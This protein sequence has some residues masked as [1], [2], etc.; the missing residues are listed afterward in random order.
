MGAILAGAVPT[1]PLG[2]WLLADLSDA[3]MRIVVSLLVLAASV[4]VW[5]GFLFR[6][7][8]GPVSHGLA[9]AVSG[10][11]FGMAAIGGLPVVIYLLAAS[12]AAATT[13]AVLALHLML[14]GLYGAAV[15]GAFGLFT[16]ESL[17]RVML[18][19]PP[20]LAGVAIG[21]RH[22]QASSHR[23]WRRFT[24]ALLISLSIMGLVRA[25]AG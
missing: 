9:G 7:P 18:F 4:M 25:L 15:T 8:R 11:M 22:F 19:L 20:L 1:L 5:R 10:A 6:E 2:A 17:W 14:M 23:N 13:R 3:A 21:G 24:L 12:V 16:V